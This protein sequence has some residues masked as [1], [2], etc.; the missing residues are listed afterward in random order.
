MLLRPLYEAWLL[1][2]TQ[3]PLA[4]WKRALLKRALVRDE[5]LRCLAAELAQFSQEPA[6]HAMDKAP[7][8]RP[9][10]RALTAQPE[11]ERPLFPNAW[12]PAGA[13][14]FLLLLAMVAML[15]RPAQA[16]ATDP[17][18]GQVLDSGTSD[19]PAPT[20]LPTAMALPTTVI[21]SGVPT[22][23]I[24]GVPTSMLGG[25][26]LAVAKSPLNAPAD[27]A[28]NTAAGNAPKAGPAG[29]S[30]SAAATVALRPTTTA[31]AAPSVSPTPT[32]TPTPAPSRFGNSNSPPAAGDATAIS[33]S[34]AAKP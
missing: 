24:S 6:A 5:A 17:Q 22:A 25:A 3:G 13:I 29:I 10:L 12:V 21:S 31:P 20:A 28:A 23:V 27:S 19:L 33:P 9:R 7:D 8:L 32:P 26:P 4:P 2:A 1:D 14:A 16:P 15:Q 18:L 30:A 11:A 34:A